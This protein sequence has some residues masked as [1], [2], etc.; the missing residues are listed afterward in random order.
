ML[1]CYFGF[2]SFLFLKSRVHQHHATDMSATPTVH[3]MLHLRCYIIVSFVLTVAIAS[4]ICLSRYTS[5]MY[6]LCH[7]S[8]IH[9][10]IVVI[11]IF[12][13]PLGF[14]T[15]GLPKGGMVFPCEAW[16]MA[17]STL[18]CSILWLNH[19]LTVFIR[20][21]CFSLLSFFSFTSL[22]RSWS[23]M[24]YSKGGTRFHCCSFW[25]W[26]CGTCSKLSNQAYLNLFIQ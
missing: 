1:F 24:E 11:K 16:I 22:G 21:C 10:I 19:V 5:A 6:S 14:Q 17:K 20:N 2:V 25:P 3:S 9:V 15:H 8:D 7:Y 12:T 13:P 4:L 23:S 26:Y 18:N